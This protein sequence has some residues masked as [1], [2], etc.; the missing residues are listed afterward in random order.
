MDM[1]RL[2][3]GNDEANCEVKC[4]V[5]NMDLKNKNIENVANNCPAY[6]DREKLKRFTHMFA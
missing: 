3:M 1:F 4:E 5:Y 6:F 2:P